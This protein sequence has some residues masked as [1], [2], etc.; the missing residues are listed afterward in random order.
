MLRKC[1]LIFV[2]SQMMNHVPDE[3][4]GRKDGRC[5]RMEDVE[6]W[7]MWKERKNTG[8]KKNHESEKL[9]KHAR[10]YISRYLIS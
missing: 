5:G 6:G 7:K 1:L 8:R 4:Y 3:I 9:E 2:G 10:N